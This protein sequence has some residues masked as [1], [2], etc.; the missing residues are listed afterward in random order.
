MKTRCEE[1]GCDKGYMSHRKLKEHMKKHKKEKGLVYFLSMSHYLL[2]AELF[3][4][5][6][7]LKSQI[8]PLSFVSLTYL[9]QKF[10][11]SQP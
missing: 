2:L 9:L 10:F 1:D 3:M 11:P 8:L 4:V 5:N 7:A 6:L